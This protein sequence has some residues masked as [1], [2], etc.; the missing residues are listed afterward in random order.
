MFNITNNRHTWHPT[1]HQNQTPYIRKN[2]PVLSE[3]LRE[4]IETSK[5][6]K[7]KR[8]ETS[9]LNIWWVNIVLLRFMYNH[10]N[11]ATEGNQKSG[12]C[13]TL[14]E[15]LQGFF[16]IYSTIDSTTQYIP[17]NSLEHCT[18]TTSMTNN[19]PGRD[20]NQVP[21]SFEPQPGGMIE[22]LVNKQSKIMKKKL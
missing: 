22:A 9:N 2:M 21:L 1:P 4:F 5:F 15:W 8:I 14:F 12:H 7:A 11:I 3:C 13:P 10:G 6:V 18:C 16:I 17:L 19:R 20:S